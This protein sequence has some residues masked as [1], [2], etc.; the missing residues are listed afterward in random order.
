MALGLG[1]FGCGGTETGPKKDAAPTKDVMGRKMQQE[2]E[3]RSKMGGGAPG[4]E[5]DKDKDKD[6]GKDKNGKDKDK[7]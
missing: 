2:K 6:K 3:H 5:A 1:G 4:G 7:E